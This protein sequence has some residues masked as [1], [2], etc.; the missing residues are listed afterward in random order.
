MPITR[1]SSTIVRT[2]C[3]GCSPSVM[4]VTNERSILSTSK[5]SECRWFSELYPVPK[6]SNS[7]ETPSR[8]RLPSTSIAVPGSGIRLDSVISRPSCW[9]E[10]PVRRNSAST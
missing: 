3:S 10:T 1:A 6:S 8:R 7:S 4:R 9:L 5:G 2:I